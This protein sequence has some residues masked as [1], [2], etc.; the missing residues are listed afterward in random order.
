M[1]QTESFKVTK[2]LPPPLLID[3][4][5]WAYC[6]PLFV[7]LPL[8]RWYFQDFFFSFFYIDHPR[9]ALTTIY[10]FQIYITSVMYKF[11]TPPHTHYMLI[12]FM[13]KLGNGHVLLWSLMFPLSDSGISAVRNNV[14][15]QGY[16]ALMR[17]PV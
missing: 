4:S 8:F 16:T 1:L 12:H 6:C 9:I 17:R 2:K 11:H 5:V 15:H 10:I 13:L 14:E 7:S 3:I